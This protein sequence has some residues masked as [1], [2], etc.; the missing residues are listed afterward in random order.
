ME[1]AAKAFD[2]SAR[3]VL[4]TVLRTGGFAGGHAMSELPREPCVVV[5]LVGWSAWAELG[6][7]SRLGDDVHVGLCDGKW[8]WCWTA[9]RGVSVSRTLQRWCDSDH[10]R[11]VAVPVARLLAR[12]DECRRRWLLRLGVRRSAFAVAWQWL[13]DEH[14]EERRCCETFVDAVLAHAATVIDATATT[15]RPQQAVREMFDSLVRSEMERQEAVRKAR[16]EL[17]RA[18]D[19]AMLPVRDE[20]AGKTKLAA[21]IHAAKVAM[22]AVGHAVRLHGRLP[23]GACCVAVKPYN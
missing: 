20:A 6:W 7:P 19:A 23:L 10:N 21:M 13:R 11:F 1:S 9:K 5:A 18:H 17:D 4:K 14:H 3:A 8:I 22:V 12:V 15:D 16:R 2:E